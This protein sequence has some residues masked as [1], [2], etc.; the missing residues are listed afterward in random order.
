MDSADCAAAAVRSR[1]AAYR[2]VA[3]EILGATR[4]ITDD[5]S[6]LGVLKTD[7]QKFR[8]QIDQICGAGGP[9]AHWRPGVQIGGYMSECAKSQVALRDR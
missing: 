2:K 9:A 1:A 6:W 3:H 4:T 5:G 7:R 8:P